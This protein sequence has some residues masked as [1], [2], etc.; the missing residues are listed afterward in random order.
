[1]DSINKN[2]L[3]I[4]TEQIKLPSVECQLVKDKKMTR[5]STRKKAIRDRMQETGEPYSVAAHA[6]TPIF[7]VPYP[8]GAE[9][10][11]GHF[12][13]SAFGAPYP[14]TVCSTAVIWEDGYE[15]WGLCDADDDFRDKGVPCPFHDQEAFLAYQY[16]GSYYRPYWKGTE[17][18]VPDHTPIHFHENGQSLIMSANHP[19]HGELRVTAREEVPETDEEEANFKS[20]ILADRSTL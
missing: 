6:I 13:W 1:M 3:I 2:S 15:G 4:F 16:E 12:T 10:C 9:E 20:F 7:G 8:V 14:D 18:R 19:K 17:E 5:N 11:P